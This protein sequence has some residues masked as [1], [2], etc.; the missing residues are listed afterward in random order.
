MNFFNHFEKKTESNHQVS[1][2]EYSWTPGP[3]LNIPCVFGGVGHQGP[4]SM[5]AGPGRFSI[6]CGPKSNDIKIPNPAPA[7]LSHLDRR[8]HPSSSRPASAQR[9]GSSRFA[10]MEY[11]GLSPSSPPGLAR[12]VSV[13]LWG[14][15]PRVLNL[16][17]S[18]GSSAHFRKKWR[19]NKLEASRQAEKHVAI[20]VFCL[21][22]INVVTKR[23]NNTDTYCYIYIY[24]LSCQHLDSLASVLTQA[25]YIAAE[26]LFTKHCQTCRRRCK[27]A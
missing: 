3:G 19:T 21:D 25:L 16:G 23:Q 1:D 12:S 27:V 7:L 24:P 22:S 18:R 11:L 15:R 6:A 2:F 26:L 14:T 17:P 13:Y 8:S 4:S 5:A 10:H 20:W 9:E